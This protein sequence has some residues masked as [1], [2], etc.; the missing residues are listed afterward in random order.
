MVDSI[1]SD[2]SHTKRTIDGQLKLYAN[3]ELVVNDEVTVQ[4]FDALLDCE[5]DML[6]SDGTKSDVLMVFI[7]Y[8]FVLCC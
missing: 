2:S 5:E 3:G 8:L 1:L 6:G 7:I 4:A